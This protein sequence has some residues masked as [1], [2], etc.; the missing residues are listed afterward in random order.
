MLISEEYESVLMT[1]SRSSNNSCINGILF[2]GCSLEVL[3]QVTILYAHLIYGVEIYYVALTGLL[4]S[5]AVTG[6]PPV[7]V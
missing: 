2:V 1:S 3:V 7:E 5:S 4:L 6:G